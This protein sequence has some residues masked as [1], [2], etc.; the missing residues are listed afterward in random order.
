MAEVIS[1]VA[2]WVI[3]RCPATGV[4]HRSLRDK[5][6]AY[7]SLQAGIPSFWRGLKQADIL[8]PIVVVLAAAMLPVLIRLLLFIPML[9]IA[10]LR[11]HHAA[12]RILSCMVS[13]LYLLFLPGYYDAMLAMT[14]TSAALVALE[15]Y[16][17][18]R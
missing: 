15:Y 12:A 9:V 8:I 10:V 5:V 4:I 6:K 13:S 1:P 3:S 14:A 16:R 11:L 18:I 7:K 2:L 17:F